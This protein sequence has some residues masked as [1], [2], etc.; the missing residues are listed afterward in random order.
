M[1]LIFHKLAF[2]LKCSFSIQSTF[3]LSHFVTYSVKYGSRQMAP[4]V[5][6]FFITG[7][8]LVCTDCMQT[9]T[10]LRESPACSVCRLGCPA[11]ALRAEIG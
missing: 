4:S 5:S 10:L 6:Y 9:P 1:L 11:T 7:S 3:H 8:V 2:S